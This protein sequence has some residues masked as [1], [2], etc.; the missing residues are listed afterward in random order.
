MFLQ[1][2]FIKKNGG[3]VSRSE[4]MECSKDKLSFSD[5][6]LIMDQ[7]IFNYK[8]LNAVNKNNIILKVSTLKRTSQLKRTSPYNEAGALS[9]LKE[10][11]R[12]SKLRETY[13]IIIGYDGASEYYCDKLSRFI[14]VFERKLRHCTYITILSAYGNKWIEETFS[15]QLRREVTEIETN[16]NRHV[17]MALE[18]FSFKDYTGYFFEQRREC[19]AEVAIDK[20]L[21]N[22]GTTEINK[23]QILSI[24]EKARKT[25]LW[26]KLFKGYEMEFL[27]E[28][29]EEIRIIR[30]D[31]MHNKEIKSEKFDYNKN[32]LRRCNKKLENAISKI[33]KEKYSDIVSVADVLLSLNETIKAIASITKQAEETLAPILTDMSKI[34]NKM[35]K[36]IN[37]NQ[38]IIRNLSLKRNNVNVSKLVENQM[39]NSFHSLQKSVVPESQLEKLIEDNILKKI[40]TSSSQIKQISECK[41]KTS[42]LK[43]LNNSLSDIT[44][45]SEIPIKNSAMSAAFKSHGYLNLKKE[46]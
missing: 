20:I 38:S 28:K 40:T 19:D 17:E 18:C 36:A 30:N 11:I 10:T 33:E 43:V 27:Q 4:I 29:I 44:K 6:K 37:N 21:K 13:R 31:V 25:S 14:S 35:N 9:R 34:V 24:A 16:K 41:I 1:I 42:E 3:K 23:E 7:C 22:S 45:I 39:L 26:E 8:F 32:L 15:D 2:I 46:E 5:N 12:G